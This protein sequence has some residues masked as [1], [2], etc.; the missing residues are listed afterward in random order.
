MAKK[1]KRVSLEEFTKN[2]HNEAKQTQVVTDD[3]PTSLDEFT[4]SE[5]LDKSLFVRSSGADLEQ[6]NKETQTSGLFVRGAASDLADHTL[7]PSNR[8]KNNTDTETFR[9]VARQEL[10]DAEKKIPTELFL[11][12]DV[13]APT[14]ET[15]KGPSGL[16]VR[17]SDSQ[18]REKNKRELEEKFKLF[19]NLLNDL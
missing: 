15:T 11:R 9:R 4:Q 2:G 6:Q 5:K 10:V 12:T 18:L 7:P 13:A 17:S 1:K 14:S 3:L 16:F 19:K 8:E